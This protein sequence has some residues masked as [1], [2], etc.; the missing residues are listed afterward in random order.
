MCPNISGE[1]ELLQEQPK[2]PAELPCDSQKN[3]PKSKIFPSAAQLRR[4]AVISA[5]FK[6]AWAWC[7]MHLLQFLEVISGFSQGLFSV[8]VYSWDLT[9]HGRG[10]F[11]CRGFSV[12]EQ[13]QNS[14]EMIQKRFVKWSVCLSPRSGSQWSPAMIDT[15]CLSSLSF[16]FPGVMSWQI[17]YNFPAKQPLGKCSKGG[18]CKCWRAWEFLAF[19]LSLGSFTRGFFSDTAKVLIWYRKKQKNEW[20]GALKVTLHHQP[21]GSRSAGG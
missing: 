4:A 10:L 7:H 3:T 19:S 21:S 5:C 8:R 20:D 2:I 13:L 17:Y 18:S 14:K 9:G 15:P 11:V 6:Q 12:P 16:H 1:A